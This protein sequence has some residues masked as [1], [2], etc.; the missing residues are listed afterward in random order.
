MRHEMGGKF[1]ADDA[2]L[3]PAFSGLS[4]PSAARQASLALVPVPQGERSQA[5]PGQ[6]TKLRL[7]PGIFCEE[8]NMVDNAVMFAANPRAF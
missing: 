1:A 5:F 7:S 3:P 2:R 6:S 8:F 4:L